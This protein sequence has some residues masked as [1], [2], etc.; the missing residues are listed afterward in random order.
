MLAGYESVRKDSENRTARQIN[1][2]LPLVAVARQESSA[3]SAILGNPIP[4]FDDR[5]LIENQAIV[6]LKI[7]RKLGGRREQPH[8]P[9]F[10]QFFLLAIL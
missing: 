6:Q 2:K 8:D 1:E 3:S 4:F 5:F 9:I 7:R 10:K